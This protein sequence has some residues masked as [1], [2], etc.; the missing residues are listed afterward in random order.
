VARSTFQESMLWCIPTPSTLIGRHTIT[1]DPCSQLPTLYTIPVSSFVTNY[2]HSGC[3]W[4]QQC[5]RRTT[6]II[7][8]LAGRPGIWDSII[9][10]V[11]QDSKRRAPSHE[12]Q[13]D[14]SPP[15]KH[16]VPHTG[17]AAIA[18]A[19]RKRK[20]AKRRW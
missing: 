4:R 14:G 16:T 15:A 2:W 1:R 3:W 13:Y 7:R 18:K 19:S 9:A 5:Q 17:N 12:P 11:Y 6:F 20:P 8:R 10:D